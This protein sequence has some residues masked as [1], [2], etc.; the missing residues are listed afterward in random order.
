MLQREPIDA[1]LAAGARVWQYLPS[2][3][4]AKTMLADDA[5]VVVGSM[6]LDLLSLRKL[7]EVALLIDDEGIG[8]VLAK[9]FESDCTHARELGT[10]ASKR[11]S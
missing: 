4:H 3:M 1:L 11:L 9:S 6:N 10:P 5:L 2:M 7:D 8:T